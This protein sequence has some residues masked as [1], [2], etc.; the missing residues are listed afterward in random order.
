[1]DNCIEFTH[2]HKSTDKT[3]LREVYNKP[4][5]LKM[6]KECVSSFNFSGMVVVYEKGR[7]KWR[8]DVEEGKFHGKVIKYSNF[9]P[10]TLLG[11]AS[12]YIAGW[13]QPVFVANFKMDLLDGSLFVYRQDGTKTFVLNYSMGMPD[14]EQKHYIEYS[15]FVHIFQRG[16]WIDS[17]KLAKSWLW[18]D[19]TDT[20]ASLQEV[21][22][23]H[24]N[25]TNII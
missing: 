19:K 24:H 21:K 8:A 7:V 23:I 18:S 6:L 11:T 2:S 25:N 16:E 20:S 5:D 10:T 4:I 22:R 12:G 1:M 3:R 15:K 17:K 14:G 13:L 9:V